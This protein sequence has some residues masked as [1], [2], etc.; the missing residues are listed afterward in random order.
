LEQQEIEENNIDIQRL[1]QQLSAA[2]AGHKELQHE[3][4]DIIRQQTTFSAEI[5]QA[6]QFI[7]N[8]RLQLKNLDSQNLLAQ[9]CNYYP[10]F[11]PYFKK[12]TL[13]TDNF[14]DTK[15]RVQQLV[16]KEETDLR[17]KL[18][19]IK[20]KLVSAMSQ[21]LRRFPEEHDF[22]AEIQ[23]LES[24]LERRE[25]IIRE[26]LPRHEQRF[27]ERLNEKVTHE[28]GLFRGALETERREIVNK[29][30]T[31]NLSLRQLEYRPNKYI[32]LDPQLVRR[33]EIVEFK[34]KLEQCISQS[35]EDT[36]EANEARF[37]KIQELVNKLKDEKHHRWRDLVTDV[38]QW[39]D[40]VANVIDKDT[41]ESV[42]SYDN[43]TGQS[44]GEKAK[45][46]FTILVAA[47]AY[48]YDL[49]P[50][51]DSNDR[52]QFVVVDEMFSKVDDQH[53]EY[54]LELFKQFGLQLL[55]V[56]PLDAKALVTIPYVGCYLHINKKGNK[57]EVFQMTAKEFKQVTQPTKSQPS[58]DNFV[59]KPK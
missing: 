42:S 22:A 8:A 17:K 20:E 6:K 4:D 30:E 40:F 9:H 38:R 57:S 54:A 16:S 7:E 35:F 34:Q 18:D 32:Q 29:I 24:F 37:E 44:G 48:Q 27:K 11:E 12:I 26:D 47:I 39:F 51:S 43:S 1:K 52:F 28:I 41:L 49:D 36:L 15:N 55:I 10:H 50:K 2:E 23:Y 5:D 25:E 14:F 21:Y 13:T 56:A 59:S 19:P 58:Q 53:A 3:R 31:L 33:P 46:A 45:L